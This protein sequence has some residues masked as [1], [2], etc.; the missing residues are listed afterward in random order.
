MPD[1]E[2]EQKIE[3]H[4]LAREE[5]TESAK[6]YEERKTGLGDEFLDEI[7]SKLERIAR[8]PNSYSIVYENVRQA[9][10]TRFPYLIYYIIKSPLVFILS[11]W[12]KK[13]DRDGWKKR[14]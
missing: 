7:E 10:L 3:F 12:H 9:S 1:K 13:R 6:W 11:I 8:K 4:S 5:L 14:I 2:Y